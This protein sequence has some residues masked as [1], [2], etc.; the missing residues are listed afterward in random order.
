MA[1]EQVILPALI[2]GCNEL[3]QP[4]KIEV[5]GEVVIEVADFRIVTVA[6]NNLTFK[7]MPVMSELIFNIRQ[8]SIEIVIPLLPCRVEI[9]TR[10]Y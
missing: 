3:L 10:G 9:L 4:E 8:L 5:M 7:I 6:I 2:T 1:A